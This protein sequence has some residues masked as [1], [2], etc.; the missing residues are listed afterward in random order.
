VNNDFNVMLFLFL[1][2]AWLQKM[3]SMGPVDNF[4]G[5]LSW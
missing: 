3:S 2:I 1:A 4:Y 5:T